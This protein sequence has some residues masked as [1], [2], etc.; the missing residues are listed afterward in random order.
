MTVYND[1]KTL[2][3]EEIRSRYS[4]SYPEMKVDRVIFVASGAE[5][6]PLPEKLVACVE[7]IANPSHLD[8]GSRGNLL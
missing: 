7:R 4:K 6:D 2:S 1:C 3:P 5:D 8:D